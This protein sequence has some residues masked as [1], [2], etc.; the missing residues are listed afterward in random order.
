VNYFVLLR[1]EW[2]E[3][4]RSSRV[5]LI[6]L[7]FLLLAVMNVILIKELPNILSSG[8]SNLPA[9]TVIQMPPATALDA[10]GKVIS[11]FDQLGVL[12]IILLFMSSI[13]GETASGVKTTLFVKPVSPVSYIG[14]KLTM[15]F[16]L[17]TV[18][19]AVSML[20]SL[21]YM[22]QFF[23]PGV[24]VG[25]FLL[26]SIVYLPKL[27]LMVGIVLFFSAIGKSSVLAGGLSLVCSLLLSVT[28][29]NG[30]MKAHFPNALSTLALQ[31]FQGAS[32]SVVQPML[33]T[34][35]LVIAL[36]IG[37]CCLVARRSA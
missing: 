23:H 3:Q 29:V 25:Y 7:L 17:V 16:L 32:P 9:G 1:K 13:A 37:A 28:A 30:W 6:P 14:A 35:A 21:Y 2:T 15:A 24:N 5:L 19:F 22:N 4:V 33:Y 27:L 34:V 36:F 18:S 11:Q 12:A 26:G 31:Y 8:A 20:V 10:A